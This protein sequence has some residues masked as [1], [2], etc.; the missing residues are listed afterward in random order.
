MD[1]LSGGASVLAFIGI[2]NSLQSI[3]ETLSAVKDGPEH[4]RQVAN[5]VGQLS[6]VLKQL[7]RQQYLP[8][9][10]GNH[11]LK[12]CVDDVKTIEDGISKLRISP[13]EKRSG[14]IWKRVKTALK[15]KDI[16]RMHKILERHTAALSL[17]LVV[18]QR[19]V[20]VE[21][22][23]QILSLK[24]HVV[25]QKGSPSSGHFSDVAPALQSQVDTM[26]Q[27]LRQ[28]QA[29]IPAQAPAQSPMGEPS[30]REMAATTADSASDNTI[31]RQLVEII[32]E[33]FLLVGEK[34]E[35][36]RSHD[37]DDTIQQLEKLL[38][39]FTC[40]NA[41][42]SELE[43]SKLSKDL[44]RTARLLTSSSRLS[45]S[46]SRKRKSPDGP[47]I[48]QER[49]RN[50]LRIETGYLTVSTTKRRQRLKTE[51]EVMNAEAFLA[52]IIFL[53]SQ[54][55]TQK[56]MLAVSISQH[57]HIEGSFLSF[58]SISINR[59]RPRES[60][61]FHLVRSGRLDDLRKAL[62][63]GTASV[64][65]HDEYGRSLLFYATR[66]PE[67]C[68]F[69]IESGLDLD[70]VAPNYLEDPPNSEA[71]FPV[72]ALELNDQ[73]KMP[74][75]LERI[76]RCRQL[77][78]EAGADPSI[79]VVNGGLLFTPFECCC[80]DGIQDSM[81]I[82]LDYGTYF[83]DIETSDRNGNTPLLLQF[84]GGGNGYHEDKFAFLI[85]RGANVNAIDV[86]GRSCLHIAIM[87]SH[88]PFRVK[89]E[90]NAVSL[91]IRS[92]G[93]VYLKD[94]SGKSASD[95]AYWRSSIAYDGE[96]V[97]SYW[98][99]F[100]DALLAASGYR[101]SDFRQNS[102]RTPRYTQEYPRAVFL[103]LWEGRQHLCPYWE[104]DQA[105]YESDAEGISSDW[106]DYNEDSSFNSDDD[107]ENGVEIKE[108]S[109]DNS[110][111]K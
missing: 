10:D 6:T 42:L 62:S 34:E 91:L 70:H 76:N 83:T 92:G 1:P 13:S 37:A 12:Q 107:D 109:L 71:P 104:E 97:G 75:V 106:E 52:S 65:D 67:V 111:G 78:L 47:V 66:Q 2:L 105:K 110:I 50:E 32:N 35:V 22:R 5:S 108:A 38:M 48:W 86:F 73:E 79:Q 43:K 24:S 64:R 49:Q 14:K 95:A 88:G 8:D 18:Q 16:D 102:P 68:K 51:G 20:I 54:K 94:A 85:K 80:F 74:A 7:Q 89:E 101:V 53:P 84:L 36:I 15:E 100:W 26:L 30:N 56:S 63:Q 82:Y 81:R 72:L 99:D 77:L 11:Q 31:S 29:H 19:D 28:L 96:D 41:D 17:Q 103:W 93:D 60:Q 55:S 87:G 98:G 23:D 9:P 39:N 59:V 69:L 90:F 44:E 21:C 3:Y 40:G 33:L 25:S 58:P 61:V 27:I 4:V 57:E 45:I 46:K